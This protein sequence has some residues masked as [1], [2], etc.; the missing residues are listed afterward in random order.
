MTGDLNNQDDRRDPRMAVPDSRRERAMHEEDMRA[1]DD[2]AP[3]QDVRVPEVGRR[4]R[5]IVRRLG[6]LLTGIGLFFIVALCGVAGL[7]YYGNAKFEEAGPLTAQKTIMI[8]RGQSSRAIAAALESEGF[9]THDALFLIGLYVSGANSKLKAGE[10]DIAAGTSMRGVMNMLVQG[11]AIQHKITIPEGLTT[12]QIVRRI[13]DH[14][15]LEGKIERAVAE[16]SLLPDTYIFPRGTTRQDV[17]KQMQNAQ[18]AFMAKAWGE[19]AGDL[20]VRKPYEALILASIVEK[21]TAKADERARVASVFV[22]RMRRRMRLQSDPTIIYGLVGGKGSLGRPLTKA[23]IAKETEYNTYRIDG[24]PPTP[25]ANP[26]KA[27]IEAVLNPLQST[28]LYFV[29]D[30]TGGHAFA[31]TLAEHNSNV[32]QWRKIERKRRA[33][34]RAKEQEKTTAEKSDAQ[35]KE[36]ETPAPSV[37]TTD[38]P[39]APESESKTRQSDQ[40]ITQTVQETSNEVQTGSVSKTAEDVSTQPS[41]VPTSEAPAAT[42]APAQPAWQPTHL[43]NTQPSD[44]AAAVK[45]VPSPE[46]APAKSPEPIAPTEPTV[47]IPSGPALSILQN[48]PSAPQNEPAPA[49]SAPAAPA[50]ELAKPRTKPDQTQTAEAPATDQGTEAAP[51]K[52]VLKNVPLPRPKPTPPGGQSSEAES[53]IS[54]DATPIVVIPDPAPVTRQSEPTPTPASSPSANL[55]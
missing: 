7:Y 6:G 43:Q 2:M 5:G 27:A 12:Q 20:P 46:P 47:T 23:D 30:G 37:A 44:Q 9:I 42:E 35:E 21:E 55:K 48:E 18:T 45:P 11:K 51:A 54:N 31:P 28:D 14:P 22:N 16:G 10:Y 29:A 26:G 36:A 25:I 39:A 52:Q 17:V 53:T 38:A 13:E 33:E 40:I 49:E 19:R 4:H 41:P 15:I 1:P 3:P 32:A 34:A 50:A 8:K 24:L